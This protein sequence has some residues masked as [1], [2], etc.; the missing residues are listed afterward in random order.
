LKDLKGQTTANSRLPVAHIMG[1]SWIKIDVKG[2]QATR[3][4][5][6]FARNAKILKD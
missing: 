1:L 6:R 3:I 4:Q 5:P 2:Q